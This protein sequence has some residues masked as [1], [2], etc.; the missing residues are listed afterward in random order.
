MNLGQV[1]AQ[2]RQVLDRDDCSSDDADGWLALGLGRVQRELRAPYLERVFYVDVAGSAM[3]DLTIPVDYIGM[4]DVLVDGSPLKR[5]TYRELSRLPASTTPEWYAR[6][7]N[8]LYFKGS[9]PVG[10]RLEILYYGEATPLTGDT[11]TNEIT[12]VC[13]DLLIYAALTYAADAYKLDNGS[14]F[15]GRYMSLLAQINQQAADDEIAAM[16]MVVSPYAYDPGM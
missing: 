4:I 9:I 3:S 11:S 8:F 7:R 13:P 10:V 5:T 14:A 6:Y 2:F 12:S 16:S 15:E 1:R